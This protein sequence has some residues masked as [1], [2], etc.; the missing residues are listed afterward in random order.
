MVR[1]ALSRL[2]FY[3]YSDTAFLESNLAIFIHQESK[4]F[5]FCGLVTSLPQE[6]N[7]SVDKDPCQ[8]LLIALLTIVIVDM[9]G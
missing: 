9:V 8:R 2:A 5:L 4:Q 7:S 3:V 6:V 1:W